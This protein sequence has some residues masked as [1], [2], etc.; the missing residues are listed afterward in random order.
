MFRRDALHGRVNETL[1]RLQAELTA[2]DDGLPEELHELVCSALHGWK[3]TLR[4]IQ[5][6]EEEEGFRT[7]RG[8]GQIWRLSHAPAVVVVSGST[9]SH[10]Q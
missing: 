1:A 4:E 7:N 2:N 5:E 3:K 6:E 10:C 9:R 8:F